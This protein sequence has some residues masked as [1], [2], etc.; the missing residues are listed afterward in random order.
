[1]PPTSDDSIAGTPIS[2]IRKIFR[3]NRR[4]GVNSTR[5]FGVEYLE[6]EFD[7]SR[8]KAMEMILGLQQLGYLSQ[9][10]DKD[11]YYS[12]TEKGKLFGLEK[13]NPPLSIDKADQIYAEFLERVRQVN[14][15]P[16]FILRITDFYLFGDYITGNGSITHLEILLSMVPKDPASFSAQ[17]EAKMRAHPRFLGIF[18]RYALPLTEVRSFLKQRSRYLSIYLPREKEELDLSEAKIF[19]PDGN[20]I[21]EKKTKSKKTSQP[22]KT[23]RKTKERP[24]DEFV[25]RLIFNERKGKSSK[26][27]IVR[28]FTE[29]AQE[30][31][32]LHGQIMDGLTTLL[33]AQHPSCTISPE[34]M[35][36]GLG[37]R[38]DIVRKTKEDQVIFYEIKTY[39]KAAISIRMALGQ[40]LEYAF[41]P[42]RPFT[43]ELCIVSHV[44]AT[45][46]DL[47]YL[48]H[49]GEKIGIK[50][51]YIH[52]D[53]STNKIAQIA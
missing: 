6:E 26:E 5:T 16:D 46:T 17:R 25:G 3:F 20:L 35:I 22:P 36:M 47:T 53:C 12:I 37:S 32:N 33:R 50:I 2:K 11:E 28:K 10:P 42:E 29:K 39:P 45:K 1:M 18:E 7:I 40:L 34:C 8:A 43:G 15:N 13:A 44:P 38:I 23:N 41:Y 48:K 4:I 9:K 52:Y 30:Q 27:Q 14:E 49:M 24:T 51:G 21:E 31:E 19:D